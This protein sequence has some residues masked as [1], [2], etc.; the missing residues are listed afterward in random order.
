MNVVTREMLLAA[1]KQATTLGQISE[2]QRIFKNSLT[3][4]VGISEEAY[5]DIQYKVPFGNM[6]F[7]HCNVDSEVYPL[8]STYV[9]LLCDKNKAKLQDN[10]FNDS[11]QQLF[12]SS[13]AKTVCK[14]FL[15][16]DLQVNQL[17]AELLMEGFPS[18]LLLMQ[19]NRATLE[20]RSPVDIDTI[21]K[22]TRFNSSASK[23][24]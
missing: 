3:I 24:T 5:V 14:S 12:S 19:V 6:R 2:T 18:M 1:D 13:T 20:D 23:N 22:I 21:D 17:E 16:D 15:M 10:F 4:F 9:N 11:K 7:I 8:I